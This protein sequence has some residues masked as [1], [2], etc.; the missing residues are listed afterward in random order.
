MA[1]DDHAMDVSVGF[2]QSGGDAAKPR[3]IDANAV[4]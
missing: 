1:D 4:R 2:L 3:A